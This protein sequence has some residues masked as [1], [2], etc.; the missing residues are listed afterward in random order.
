MSRSIALARAA[1]ILAV[2]ASTGSAAGLPSARSAEGTPF[3]KD[4][5]FV[6]PEGTTSMCEAVTLVPARAGLVIE[7]ASA[8]VTLPG[9]SGQQAAG[10]LRTTV[11]GELVSHALVLVPAPSGS[12]VVGGQVV[13]LYADPGTLVSFCADRDAGTGEANVIVGISGRLVF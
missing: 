6:V 13:R 5:A 2:L 7:Y 10:Q 3:Q 11:G 12:P 8:Q 4:V 1:S 9:G